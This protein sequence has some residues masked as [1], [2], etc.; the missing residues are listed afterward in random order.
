MYQELIEKNKRH[1]ENIKS[2]RDF[3]LELHRLIDELNN[4]SIM[5]LS[6]LRNTWRT[7]LVSMM[8]QKTQKFEETFYYNAE[9]D[10]LWTIKSKNDFI[11][12]FDLSVRIYWVPKII[13]LQNMSNIEWIKELILQ[14]YKTK[15][16]KILLVGNNI[17]IEWVTNIELY[18]LWITDNYEKNIRGWLPVVRVIPENSYKDTLLTS[19][20]NYIIMADIVNSYNIKNVLLYNYILWYLS[21]NT[22][23][24]SIREIHRNLSLNHIEI[25]HLTLIEYLSSATTT[26]ILSKCVRYDMKSQKEI[27][28]KVQYYFGDV[29]IRKS[30]TDSHNDFSQNLL[31]LELLSKWYTVHWWINWKFIFDFYAQKWDSELCIHHEVSSDKSEIRK[32]A[33]KLAKI[34]SSAEKFVIVEDKEKIVWMRK[35]EEQGVKIVELYEFVSKYLD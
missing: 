16:Y 11:T 32:T 19:L 18:P 13:I 22:Q 6:W 7:S 14:F 5:T 21:E 2:Y 3:S 34:D 17:Q 10:T 20:R 29:G 25:S 33:R 23:Y 1:I 24:S 27:S 8:L 31:Y 12:I 35:F 15:K 30:F 28:S 26:K 4:N 9:L